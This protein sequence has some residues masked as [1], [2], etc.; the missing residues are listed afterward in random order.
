MLFFE[1]DFKNSVIQRRDTANSWAHRPHGYMGICD[2]WP[3]NLRHFIVRRLIDIIQQSLFLCCVRHFFC[4]VKIL[5]EPLWCPVR[6][7]NSDKVY[8]FLCSS[9]SSIH[10]S[11]VISSDKVSIISCQ[12]ATLT[13]FAMIKSTCF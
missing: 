13:C 8:F 1:T 4:D 3:E 2:T 10:S 5:L 11:F 12:R 6:G 9:I 7:T